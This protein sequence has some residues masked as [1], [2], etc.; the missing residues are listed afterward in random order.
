VEPLTVTLG[1]VTFTVTIDME[2]VV[3][4]LPLQVIA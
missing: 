2:G 4:A 3:P 1:A